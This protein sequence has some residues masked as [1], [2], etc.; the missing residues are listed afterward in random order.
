MEGHIAGIPMIVTEK[1]LDHLAFV[2]QAEDEIFVPVMSIRLHDMPEN[3]TPADGHHRLGP[4][5]GFL[6]QTRAQ[7]PAKNDDLHGSGKAEG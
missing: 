5:L 4:E 7:T 3:R 2:T 6:V 1:F